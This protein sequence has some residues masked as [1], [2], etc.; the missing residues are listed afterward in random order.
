MLVLP[1]TLETGNEQRVNHL[2]HSTNN[3]TKSIQNIN[4][5]SNLALQLNAY[6]VQTGFIKNKYDLEKVSRFFHSNLPTYSEKALSF[7]EKLY[8]YNSFVGYYFFIRDFER[9]YTYAKKWVALFELQPQMKRHN[10]EVFQTVF[11]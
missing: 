1:K 8:L 5:F 11:P 4:S 2:I 3:A 9:G 7:Q 6:Y 10:L